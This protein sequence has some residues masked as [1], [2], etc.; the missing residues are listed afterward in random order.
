[1]EIGERPEA[2]GGFTARRTTHEYT[3]TGVEGVGHDHEVGGGGGGR[4]YQKRKRV[5]EFG[6]KGC[7]SGPQPP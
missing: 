7:S 3:Q 4:K 6:L 5:L 2:T 1:M